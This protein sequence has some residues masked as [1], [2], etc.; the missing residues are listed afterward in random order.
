[1]INLTRGEE[2]TFV[3]TLTEKSQLDR[4][5]SGFGWVF[6]FSCPATNESFAFTAMDESG[7]TARFNQF[8]VTETGDPD[9]VDLASGVIKLDPAG[10]WEYVAYEAE[11]AL[12]VVA[13]QDVAGLNEVERGTV[14]VVETE[15]VTPTWEPAA[16]SRPVWEP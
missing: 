8:T 9:E 14:D 5:A 13:S 11:D 1:M 4:T 10:T 7:A 3:V 2:N 16:E 6:V 15:S 12:S